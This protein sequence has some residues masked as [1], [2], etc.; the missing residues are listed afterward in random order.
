MST[1]PKVKV[2]LEYLGHFNSVAT[3]DYRVAKIVGAAIVFVLGSGGQVDVTKRVGDIISEIQ[4]DELSERVEVT[5]TDGKP[6][7]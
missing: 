6:R 7:S 1:K 4:A 3:H 2:A 5:V